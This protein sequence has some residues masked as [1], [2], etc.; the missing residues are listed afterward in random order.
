MEEM[1]AHVDELEQLSNKSAKLGGGISWRTIV[2]R[3]DKLSSD[4]I[5]VLTFDSIEDAREFYLCHSKMVGFGIRE[6][7][8]KKDRKGIVTYK[9]WD[10]QKFTIK[11]F[12]MDHNHQ[13]A[14]PEFVQF[15]RS[16]RSVNP[17]DLEH[18]ILMHGVGIR[19]P[20]IVDLQAYQAG[21]HNKMGYTE[22]DL[23]NAVDQF[24]RNAL[25]VGDASQV[26]A[27]LD[28]RAN[29]EPNFF[30][31][32]AVDVEK[33]LIRLFW[34][35]SQ[36]R[37][38][39]QC[40]GDVLVFDSTY[41][42][43]AYRKPLVI[44]AGV[45]H[46]YVTTIFGCALIADETEDTYKWVLET[47]LEAMEKKAPISVVTDGDGAMRN[48]IK[49]VIPSARHRLC[50]W[51][52]KR[53][54]VTHTNKGFV[55]DFDVAMDMICSHEEFERRWHLLVEKHN[56]RDNQWVVDLYNKREK[57][58]A[59]FLRGHFFAG[60]KSTQRSEQLNAT[61]HKYLQ[62][63]M[64]LYPFAHR[65]ELFLSKVRR[66]EHK[67]EC[68]TSQSSP[69]LIT[70]L[71]ELEGNAASIFTRKIFF[72]IRDEIYAEASLRLVSVVDQDKVKL[73]TFTEY[74]HRI[75]SWQVELDKSERTIICSCKK[76]ESDG[77]PCSHAFA[78]MKA[79]D[80]DEI[81][82]SCIL[83]RWTQQ[84]KPA[85]KNIYSIQ[86]E[87]SAIQAARF[88]ALCAL[89]NQMCFYAV[90][91]QQGYDEARECIINSTSR[92]KNLWVNDAPLVHKA[93]KKDN[94]MDESIKRSDFDVRDPIVVATKGQ[95]AKHS[96]HK[97]KRRQCKNCK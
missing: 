89:S 91:T 60:M 38:D 20:Q 40:F 68:I 85:E 97:R 32:Y 7:D 23:R 59:A 25:E 15:L 6:R 54:V 5:Q 51:H 81:P 92:F 63:K 48:A 43:N 61:A 74:L 19:I 62:F 2:D 10:I 77:I 22:K 44:L 34:T 35:D 88:G 80:M 16:H 8:E 69:V 84:A 79:E 21:G 31:K 17:A 41:R 94:M 87:D 50:A 83:F 39:Y 30:Y 70:H 76:L 71:R 4:E 73:Y 90:K 42:T 14:N 45:N 11:R 24:H 66:N 3:L 33:R 64:L 82:K 49:A 95:K 47:F 26:L 86:L 56:L 12:N 78:V 13:L 46:H 75:C 52:L 27:Y 28:G 1:T 57:W 37:L 67:E 65:F 72:K 58:A 29:G 93:K 55:L 96:T 53:N 36:S 18:A 9:R